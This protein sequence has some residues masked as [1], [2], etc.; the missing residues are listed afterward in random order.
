M[1]VCVCTKE[2]RDRCASAALTSST[3]AAAAAV[4]ASQPV[5]LTGRSRVLSGRREVKRPLAGF[6]PTPAS[7]TCSAGAELIPPDSRPSAPTVSPP[8]TPP[9]KKFSGR[10]GVSRDSHLRGSPERKQFSLTVY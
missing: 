10:G 4:A 5:I 1:C 3:A 8:P 7:A 9:K 2:R 6:A